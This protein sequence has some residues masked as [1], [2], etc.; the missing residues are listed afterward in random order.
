MARN[1]RYQAI[2]RFDRWSMSAM[3]ILRQLT[4][5]FCSADTP[6]RYLVGLCYLTRRRREI[7]RK[8]DYQPIQ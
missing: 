7:D 1:C 3:A 8:Y 4:D 6:G 2:T 5:Y